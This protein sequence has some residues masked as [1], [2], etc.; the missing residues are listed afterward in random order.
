M[1]TGTKIIRWISILLIVLSGPLGAEDL[2]LEKLYP[3]SPLIGTPPREVLWSPDESRCFFLWN[4]GAGRN[5]EL[6]LFTPDSETDPQRVDAFDGQGISSL[7]WGRSS[8]EIIYLKGTSICAFDIAEGKETEIHAFTK[9]SR[10]LSF[11][12]D[13]SFVCYLQGGNIWM[14]DFAADL[15]SP[16]TDLDTQ[17][18]RIRR[19]FISP[20]SQRIAFQAQELAETRQVDIPRFERERVSLQTVPRPFPGDP[21]N[22]Q[23][24]GIAD[25]QR[26][27][28]EWIPLRLENV[29]TIAWSPSGDTLLLEESSAFADRR[30]L[31]TCRADD[32]NA[33]LVFQEV[34]PLFT[35]SWIWSS[36]WIDEGTVVLTSDRSGFCHLHALDLESGELKQL[37][38]GTW[39]VLQTFPVCGN[40]LYY[41]ANEVRPEDRDLF[42]LNL[43]SGESLRLADRDGVYRP[44]PSKTGKNNCVLFSDD[45]TPF[46]FY[47]VKDGRLHRLTDSPAPDFYRYQ[48]VKTSYLDIPSESAGVPIRAKMMVPP[49]FDPQKKYS[50][51]IGSV[52]SNAVLN[53]WGGRDAHPT[54]GLDQYLVQVEGYILLNLDMRGSLGYGRKFREDMYKGY[55]TVDIEDIAVAANYLKSLPYIEAD[56]IGIWGSSYGGLMTLMSLFKHPD[57]FACGIAGA[58]AS[59]V[60]H[61]LPGQMEVMKSIDDDEAYRNASAYFWSQGLKAPLMII[62]GITDTT[63][64]FMDSVSL[65]RKMIQQGKDFEL[66][67]LPEASHGWDTGSSYQ[68]VFAFKKMVDFFNRNL[69]N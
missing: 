30:S 23:K 8:N 1:M 58:P 7:C 53:Q 28:A 19:M 37:T 25:V 55:G 17:K 47:F 63:V 68:T 10:G 45:M 15:E 9:R 52:Y 18:N 38:S 22:I 54:W 69:R 36:Q 4:E 2:T 51:V 14:Y 62:H 12:P 31:Y 27:T 35:F 59:N 46:D 60:Y 44:F 33:E 24:I 64:L 57:L 43:E 3:E 32:M 56:K 66:V 26:R 41:I 5:R 39:E 21:G 6:Y 40:E 42:K 34:S 48:W 50:A 49:D 67:V 20:D 16:L 13:G 65:A 11:S 29:L 61:A